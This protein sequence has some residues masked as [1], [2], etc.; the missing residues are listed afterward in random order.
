MNCD[1]SSCVLMANSGISANRIHRKEIYQESWTILLVHDAGLKRNKCFDL[2]KLLCFPSFAT[3]SSAIIHTIGSDS[4]V[5]WAP[6]QARAREM[7]LLEMG[8]TTAVK[9]FPLSIDDFCIIYRENFTFD[10]NSSLLM[11]V[12]LFTIRYNNKT[13]GRRLG[14]FVLAQCVSGG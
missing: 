1:Q 11:N 5:M 2:I 4:N 14:S 13:N 12:A 7:C 6:I 9:S 10:A 3:H 8:R